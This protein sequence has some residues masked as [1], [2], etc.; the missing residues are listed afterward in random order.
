MKNEFLK[1][2]ISSIILIPIVFISIIEGNVFFNL[3]LIL[4]L[5]ISIY[6]WKKISF[7]KLF[8]LGIIFLFF[9]FFCIYKIRNYSF[10]DNINQFNF[11][12]ITLLCLS[13][14][15][16]GY[17]TGSILKGPKLTKISPNKTISGS[18]GSFVF[19]IITIYLFLQFSDFFFNYSN[20]MDFKFIT[21]ILFI[22]GISQ[23]GD[24]LI[25]YF[26]RKSKLKDTGNIIPGH[27]G[28]LD[29][30]DGVIFAFP[31]YY[32]LIKSQLL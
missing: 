15:I 30:I 16:G 11:F 19:P 18:F 20:I 5:I 2:V 8:F 12:L 28:L 17:F 25:S 32:V 3:L 24:L 1:R 26:K 21:L 22:S 29:R 7:N 23:I 31:V 10:D 14:D 4:L 6:E 13:T 27:G 9:S